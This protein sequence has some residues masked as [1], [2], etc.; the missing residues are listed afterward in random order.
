MYFTDSTEGIYLRITRTVSDPLWTE[1]I[2]RLNNK[3]TACSVAVVA[4][5]NTDPYL[6]TCTNGCL[7]YWIL[8]RSTSSGAFKA[9]CP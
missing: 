2:A 1:A 3:Y 7:Y 8:R 9:G 4:A 5:G 6:Y